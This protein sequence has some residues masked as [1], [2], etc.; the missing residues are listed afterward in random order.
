MKFLD[1]NKDIVVFLNTK[2]LWSPSKD[3][4]QIK[5]WVVICLKKAKNLKG[6]THQVAQLLK[7]RMSNLVPSMKKAIDK[8]GKEKLVALGK[9]RS[10]NQTR[11]KALEQ[12]VQELNTTDDLNQNLE[13]VAKLMAYFCVADLELLVAHNALSEIKSRGS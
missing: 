4:V 7:C 6:T 8:G 9:Q 1:D 2:N 3:I 13:E 12:K 10:Y 5:N 11:I